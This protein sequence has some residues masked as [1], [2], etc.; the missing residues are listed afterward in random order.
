MGS[1]R[2]NMKHSREFAATAGRTLDILINIITAYYGQSL[3]NLGTSASCTC[4]DV[5]SYSD[6]IHE[7]VHF[8]W[9]CL[10][11]WKVTRTPFCN[12]C[13]DQDMGINHRCLGSRAILP[14]EDF[15][16]PW[17]QTT[18]TY[19]NHVAI[20]Q[21][22]ATDYSTQIAQD[23]DAVVYLMLASE[24]VKSLRPNAI[25]IAEDV[26]GMPGLC[27]PVAEGALKSAAWFGY[28]WT[29]AGCAEWEPS[30]MDSMLLCHGEVS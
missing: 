18:R 6:T 8:G 25:M 15:K 16:H 20:P 2:N 4:Q 11:S 10:Y 5:L 27:V 29:T 17:T 14:V 13:K 7:Y 26:S 21:H 19:Q 3:A 28:V 23:V 24:L 1:K 30:P 9:S 22:P 12:W